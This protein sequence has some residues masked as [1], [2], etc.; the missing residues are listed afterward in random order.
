[1]SQTLSE[2][3]SK[4]LLWSYGVPFPPERL[5]RGDDEAVAAVTELGGYPMAAKLCGAAIAHKSERDLVRLDL[6]DE[7]ALRGAVADLLGRAEDGDGEVGV[8]VAPM[9]RGRRELIA[10]AHRD[11]QFGMTVMLGVGGVL[12]EAVNDVVFRL[13]PLDRAD[14]LDMADDLR[15]AALLGPFRGESA[16]DRAALAGLV[17]G[18]A[19]FAAAYPGLVAADLNPVIIRSD[20]SPLAVDALVEIE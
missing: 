12:A 19:A 11:A 9:V 15:S 18:L 17:A 13:A 10:G 3:E 2:A 20:G 4:R 16:V 8:L 7:A 6:E 5:V 14:A 1:M